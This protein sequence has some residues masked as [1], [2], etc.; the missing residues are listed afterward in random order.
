MTILPPPSPQT[1]YQEP[2]PNRVRVTR[3][4]CESLRNNDFLTG[5][6]ELIDGEVISKMGQNPPHAY[7]IRRL[8]SF[9]I[10]Q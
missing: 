9:L 6:Y 8:F 2:T 5:R 7:V 3:R 4:M 1:A 10:T